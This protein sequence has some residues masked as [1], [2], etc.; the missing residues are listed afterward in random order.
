[1]TRI[2]SSTSGDRCCASSMISTPL[3]RIG[4]ER[5]QELVQR[6]DQLVLRGRGDPPAPHRLARD[7][8][9]VEQDLAQQ[10][11]DRQE[12]IQDQRRERRL[13]ELLEQRAADRRL[14]GADVAGEDDEAFR[15]ADRLQQAGDGLVVRLAAVEEARVGREREGRLYEAVELL[16]HR[17]RG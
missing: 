10:L 5:Q 8:A 9:E 12:R 17:R 1:M 3:P 16:V 14:A 2:C 15:A 7:D 6:A 4:D 11:L 13:V